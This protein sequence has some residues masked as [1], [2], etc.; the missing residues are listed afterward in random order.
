MNTSTK[1]L[2]RLLR[3]A[4]DLQSD[5][6]NEPPFGF[7]TRVLADYRSILRR[8]SL[9]AAQLL[10]R[11]IL[12]SLGVILLA[13]AGAYHEWQLNEPSDGTTDD[14][15]FADSAIGAAFDE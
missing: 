12:L 2:E 3:A 11:V 15:A 6:P 9:A 7:V 4:A 10:R 5:V 1:T 13:S 8:D 14:Y